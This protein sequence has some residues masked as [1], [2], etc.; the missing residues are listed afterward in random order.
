PEY[1][2]RG[3]GS[4]LCKVGLKKVAQVGVPFVVVLGH[5]NFYSRF[6]FRPASDYGITCVYQDV[7]TAAFMIRIFNPKEMAE[8]HGIAYYREEFDQ[9]S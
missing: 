4:S 2:N 5:P 6:G 3:I 9:V 1:Q 7:P 8:V